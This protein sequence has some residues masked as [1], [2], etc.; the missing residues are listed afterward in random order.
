[1]AVRAHEKGLELACHI[2]PDI[3]TGLLGDPIRL[4]QVLINLIGNAIKFTE[5]GEV[6]I[7]VQK[8]GSGVRD[9]WSVIR[10]QKIEKWNCSFL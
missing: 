6:F 8:H 10:G 5:K 4:R 1:M 9:Q 7:Q 2:M 3:P